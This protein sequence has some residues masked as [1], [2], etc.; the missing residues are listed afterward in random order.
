METPHIKKILNAQTDIC[1]VIAYICA[2]TQPI[3][4]LKSMTRS[5]DGVHSNKY[6]EVRELARNVL[7]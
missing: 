7:M 4:S 5:L 3:V 1:I 2:K 6:V